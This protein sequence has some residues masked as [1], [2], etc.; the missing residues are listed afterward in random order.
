MAKIIQALLS[1]TAAVSC[2][3]AGA[4]VQPGIDTTRSQQPSG[5]RT[6][7]ALPPQ[8]KQ[9][10]HLK[11]N[12][13]L[14]QR[15]LYA[16]MDFEKKGD[17]ARAKDYYLH[18]LSLLEKTKPNSDRLTGSVARLEGRIVRMYQA[19]RTKAEGTAKIKQ[20]EEQIAVLARLE[21]LNQIYKSYNNLVDNTVRAQQKTAVADLKNTKESLKPQ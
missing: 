8:S 15:Y 10:K 17:L 3:A 20:D 4:Q 16:G 9:P 14:W 1:V 11:A 21:R 7:D 19:P 18:S 13:P 2:T 5:S 6:S 12:A